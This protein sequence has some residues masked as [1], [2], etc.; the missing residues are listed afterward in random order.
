MRGRIIWAAVLLVALGSAAFASALTAAGS[1]PTTRAAAAS[2]LRAGDGRGG[3]RKRRI[4]NF[5]SPTYVTHP[6]GVPHYLYVVEA[7]GRVRVLHRGNRRRRPFLDIRRLVSAGGERGLLSIAF[8]P[9]YR[10]NHLFYAY[11][12]NR[13]GNLEIAE[14]RARNNRNAREASRRRVIVIRHP[15]F[16][17]HNGGQLQFGP[18]GKLYAGTGDGGGAGDPRE[19][20]QDK[21]SLLGKLLRIDPTPRN[22]RRG[23]G[24]PRSNPYVKGKGRNEIY[25]RGLRN[26]WRFS[27]DGNRIVIGDVGQDRREEIDYETIDGA[28][29]ANF[30][31]DAFEG[32]SRYRSAEASRPP[33]R[34]SRPIAEYGHGGGRCSITGGYVVRDPRV[35]ALRGRYVYGDLC[36]GEIRSLVPELDGGRDDRRVAVP[37]QPG[38]A[39][40]GED[41]AGRVYYASASSGRVF[42]FVQE[43]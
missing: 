22:R 15:G 29:G 31:W 33:K 20:A 32:S 13:A 19:N 10:R 14:F 43:G 27:F 28:R 30:G 36:T 25:A 26:P 17:N 4:G 12:T 23:H 8:D 11:Y 18:R 39:T 34:H 37:A 9:K 24:V 21:G 2:E 41:A 7:A 35:P 42:M 38:L 3:I 6:P 5:A 16:A 40:F 1:D